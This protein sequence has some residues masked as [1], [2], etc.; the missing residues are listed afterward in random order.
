MFLNVSTAYLFIGL[1]RLWVGLK[2]LIDE[3]I[4]ESLSDF[5]W[6]PGIGGQCKLRPLSS[7]SLGVGGGG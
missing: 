6:D 4:Q 7:R 2:K 1:L 5:G 3:G